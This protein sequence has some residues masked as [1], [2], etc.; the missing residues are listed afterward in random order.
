VTQQSFLTGYGFAQA[1]PGPLFTFA[2]FLGVAIQGASS[3]VGLGLVALLA[4]FLPGLLAIAAALSF[5][6]RIRE[7]RALRTALPGINASVLGVLAA[8]WVRPV[9]STAIHSA[10]DVVI[11]AAAL[12]L[13]TAGKVHP[14]VVVAALVL[15][16]VVMVR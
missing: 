13:L 3:R 7:S 2:A 4:I 1:I 14:L 5:W 15:V 11:A 10:L 9:C 16:S 12:I 8:A 6:T